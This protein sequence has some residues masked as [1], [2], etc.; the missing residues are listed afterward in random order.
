MRWIDLRSSLRLFV[1]L[2][3]IMAFVPA[4]SAAVAAEAQDAVVVSIEDAT[5]KVGEKATVTARITPRAGYKLA[6]NY[7]NRISTLSAQDEGVDFDN[8]VVRGSIQDESL[9]FKIRV[10]PKKPGAH[11]INGV[12]RFGFVNSLD[13]D[14]HL[15][16]K[17][18]PLIATVTGTQ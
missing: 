15:D 9:V 10:T 13:G 4:G 1:R 18:L 3:I 5:A 2:V 7:R 6:D 12:L 16:I 11:V 17:S 8:T 14:Y